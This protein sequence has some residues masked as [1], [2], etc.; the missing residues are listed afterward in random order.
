MQR[1]RFRQALTLE[2]R[3][4]DDAVRLRAQVDLLPPGEARDELVRKARQIEAASCMNE[5]L[6]RRGYVRPIS[7]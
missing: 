5:W 3:L 2:E 7:A 1:R 4:T 6:N